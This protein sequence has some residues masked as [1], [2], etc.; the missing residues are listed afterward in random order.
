L[1][2]LSLISVQVWFRKGLSRAN[3]QENAVT[4][5]KWVEMVG[6]FSLITVGLN[7]Q[8]SALSTPM[9]TTWQQGERK[10]RQGFYAIR[11]ATGMG[12]PLTKCVVSWCC[13][14]LQSPND[15]IQK[16]EKALN[17]SHTTTQR[18]TNNGFRNTMKH[19]QSAFAFF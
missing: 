13:G 7:D 14:R 2:A 4:G 5:S 17:D 11:T 1:A 10:R 15:V 12:T 16:I 9:Q 18:R 3:G 6:K 8:V 19:P